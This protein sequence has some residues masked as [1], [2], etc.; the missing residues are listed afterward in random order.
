M[1]EKAVSK[2]LANPSRIWKSVGAWAYAIGLDDWR[3]LT[4]PPG[5]PSID[6]RIDQLPPEFQEMIL[7]AIRKP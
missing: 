1:H 3:D 7:R 6:A 5:K 4:R 2:A